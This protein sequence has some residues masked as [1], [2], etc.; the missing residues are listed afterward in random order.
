MKVKST[1]PEMNSVVT[2][3]GEAPSPMEKCF[4]F[5]MFSLRIVSRFV[6]THHLVLLIGEINS[7]F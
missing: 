3:Y 1:S 6:S 4:L 2:F 5:I 7:F